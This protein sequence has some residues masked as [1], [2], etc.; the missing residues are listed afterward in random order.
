MNT[1]NNTISRSSLD[2][3]HS[4]VWII[5]LTF[6]SGCFTCDDCVPNDD[7]PFVNIQFFRKNSLAAASIA[8]RTYNGNPVDT[9]SY[10]QDTTSQFIFPIPMAADSSLIIIDYVSSD[11]YDSL[12]TDSLQLNYERIFE[13][14]PKNVVKMVVTGTEVASHSFDSLALICQ[15]TVG[16]CLSNESTIKAYF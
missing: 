16:I 10:F 15:D 12:I 13:T 11:N 9:V 14:T 2:R 3:S 1:Q 8:I 6:V 7:E 4:I 5:I